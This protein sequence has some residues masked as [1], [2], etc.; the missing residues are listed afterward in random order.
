VVPVGH[1]PCWNE[2]QLRTL[3]HWDNVLSID[4]YSHFLALP[5]YSLSSSCTLRYGSWDS[6]TRLIS[7]LHRLP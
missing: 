1:G 6:H 3:K 7:F 5:Q 2:G 4:V